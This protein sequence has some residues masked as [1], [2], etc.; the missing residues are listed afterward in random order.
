MNDRKLPF[1]PRPSFDPDP[2]NW[3]HCADCKWSF[4]TGCRDGGYGCKNPATE[5]RRT[6]T[7]KLETHGS[8]LSINASLDCKYHEAKE[9]GS[10]E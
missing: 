7:G 3:V 5:R 6:I 8:C 4:E 1:E 9:A 10:V 2:D